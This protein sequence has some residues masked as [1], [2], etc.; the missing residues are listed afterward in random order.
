M[1]KYFEILWQINNKYKKR[2][3][4]PYVRSAE[5][6]IKVYPAFVI[7]VEKFS[8]SIGFF[9]RTCTVLFSSF[10]LAHTPSFEFSAFSTRRAQFEQC[11]PSTVRV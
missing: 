5:N 6:S 9:E 7:T 4:E 3:A 8:H 10:T 1:L 11:M 2:A